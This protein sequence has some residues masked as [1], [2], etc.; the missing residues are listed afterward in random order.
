MANP[1][2]NSLRLSQESLALID[3]EVAKY[4][5]SRKQ[6]AVMAALRI[7]QTEKGGPN[8]KPLG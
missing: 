4:P 5:A 2:S 1:D 3:A 8:P 7:A 6:S